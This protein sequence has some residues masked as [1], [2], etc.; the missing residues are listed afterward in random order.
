MVRR[1]PR[2]RR[3][4]VD[5]DTTEALLGGGRDRVP[6]G[7]GRAAAPLAARARRRD[8]RAR[9]PDGRDRLPARLRRSRP[10]RSSSASCVGSATSAHGRQGFW[11][12]GTADRRRWNELQNTPR[13]IKTLSDHLVGVYRR[14]IADDLEPGPLPSSANGDR[15]QLTVATLADRLRGRLAELDDERVRVA[16]ALA[17]ARAPRSAEPGPRA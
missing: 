2:H 5:A 14:A 7:V 16:A 8:R 11:Q 3:H 1:R 9:L 17:S 6:R 4:R 12:F 13:D 15:A 10:P